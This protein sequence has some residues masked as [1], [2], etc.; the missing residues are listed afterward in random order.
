MSSWSSVGRSINERCFWS[1]VI[2]RSGEV[3]SSI[4]DCNFKLAIVLQFF[5]GSGM[6]VE[7]SIST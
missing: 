3:G 4:L 1:M 6:L 7:V 2:G 5:Y